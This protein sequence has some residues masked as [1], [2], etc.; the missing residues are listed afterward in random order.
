MYNKFV[1]SKKYKPGLFLLLAY[2]YTLSFSEC[3]EVAE[4]LQSNYFSFIFFYFFLYL[5]ILTF[6]FLLISN[7]YEILTLFSR[8]P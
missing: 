1:L 8:S 7:A 2:Y 3:K 6:D 4:M 5:L